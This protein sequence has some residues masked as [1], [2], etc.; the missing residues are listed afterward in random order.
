MYL[1]QQSAAMRIFTRHV[2]YQQLHILILRIKCHTRNH[3]KWMQ[4]YAMYKDLY[5]RES[6]KEENARTLLPVS[7]CWLCRERS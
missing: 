1:L 6:S 7:C 3:K 5:C 2:D 4:I